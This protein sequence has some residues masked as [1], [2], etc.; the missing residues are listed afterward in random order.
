[1]NT[2]KWRKYPIV[3]FGFLT[4]PIRFETLGGGDYW[5]DSGLAA[6]FLFLQPFHS[7]NGKIYQVTHI[8]KKSRFGFLLY[9]PLCFHIWFTFKFQEQNEQGD[10]L[11]GTEKVLYWRFGAARWDAGDSKYICPTWYGPGLHWD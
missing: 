2:T 1:M 3:L 10:W 6:F 7:T 5:F 9:W 4:Y 8:Q 11:P